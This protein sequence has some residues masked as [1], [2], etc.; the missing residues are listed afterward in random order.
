MILDYEGN[1]EV[2]IILVKEFLSIG[3]E[4]LDVEKRQMKFRLK[5]EEE[6]FLHL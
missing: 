4:L 1:F 3:C 5:N 6:F 2:T